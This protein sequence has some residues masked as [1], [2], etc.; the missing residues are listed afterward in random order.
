M[1]QMGH[2]YQRVIIRVGLPM[3]EAVPKGY[4]TRDEWKIYY[5]LSGGDVEDVVEEIS[6]EAV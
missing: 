3:K 4:S 6:L 2:K 1:G 5:H